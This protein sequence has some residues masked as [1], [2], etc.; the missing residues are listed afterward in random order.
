MLG[1]CAAA[2]VHLASDAVLL[3]R[4]DRAQRRAA[5]TTTSSAFAETAA[6]QPSPTGS[7]VDTVLRLRRSLMWNFVPHWFP[8]IS[9][10]H[11]RRTDLQEVILMLQRA[12]LRALRQKTLALEQRTQR[13]ATRPSDAD[14]SAA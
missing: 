8:Q 2:A 6:T 4:W 13:N 11:P 3:W 7:V 12:E 1:L 9:A 10:G 14:R 5:S